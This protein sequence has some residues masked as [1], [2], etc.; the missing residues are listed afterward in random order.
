[1]IDDRSLELVHGAIDGENSAQEDAELKRLMESDTDLRAIHDQLVK[2]NETLDMVEPVDPPPGL[3]QAILDAVLPRERRN[4]LAALLPSWPGP[5]G[6]RYGV[7]AAL[8]ALVAVVALQLVPTDGRHGPEVSD[9]VGTMAGYE[10]HQSGADARILLNSR[11]INGSISGRRQDG[12]VVLDFDLA[13]QQPVE[14]VASFDG[15]GLTFN[16]FAH[17]DDAHVSIVSQGD[18]IVVKHD[19]DHRYAVFFSAPGGESTAIDFRFLLD[20]QT[21]REEVLVVPAEGR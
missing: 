10:P 14:I 15:S 20:G 4:V 6:M 19:R 12:L 11:E 3:R 9:L 8:G 17:L 16:G 18:S 1:M 5:V 13:M 2:L 21:V 7:A